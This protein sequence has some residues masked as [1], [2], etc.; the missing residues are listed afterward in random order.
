M[1]SQWRRFPPFVVFLV[2]LFIVFSGNSANAAVITNGSIAGGPSPSGWYWN[3]YSG[4]TPGASIAKEDN[5]SYRETDPNYP[6]GRLVMVHLNIPVSSDPNLF[7]ATRS[8]CAS[9]VSTNNASA[10]DFTYNPVDVALAFTYQS[11]TCNIGDTIVVQIGYIPYYTVTNY[12]KMFTLIGQQSFRYQ[13]A[14]TAPTAKDAGPPSIDA[15]N[16]SLSDG[17]LVQLNRAAGFTEADIPTMVA[18]D[19]AESKGKV[20]A[21]YRNATADPVSYDIGLAQVNDI[22]HPTYDRNKLGVNP[23]Y[24]VQAAKEIKTTAGDFTPW[25]TFKNKSYVQY[26]TRANAAYSSNATGA[27]PLEDCTGALGNISDPTTNTSTSQQDY[28]GISFNPLNYLKCLFLPSA[29]TF[30]A[31]TN[32]QTTATTHPPLSIINGIFTYIGSV[33]D[34]YGSDSNVQTLGNINTLGG[35]SMNFNPIRAAGDIVDKTAYRDILKMIRILLYAG[36]AFYAV[37]RI[38]V[39]FGS[40]DSTGTDE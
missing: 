1:S 13:A 21:V 30:S 28:C 4:N 27:L 6:A 35:G 36:F 7:T 34:G 39:S 26:L 15:G 17:Q 25:S 20:N 14:P 10:Y 29:G 24:N 40:H 31:W 33:T 8:G 32:L 12:Q 22:A 11:A 2:T 18:I 19:I 37:K 38:G 5:S 3:T 9:E 16:C 23:L